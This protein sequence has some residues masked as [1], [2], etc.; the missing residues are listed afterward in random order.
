MNQ[1]FI[2]V[3]L[4]ILSLVVLAILIKIFLNRKNQNNFLYPSSLELKII[5]QKHISPKEKFIL[6]EFD[7]K[8][9]LLLLS[10]NGNILV[11]TIFAKQTQPKQQNN[12]KTKKQNED[13]DI[14]KFENILK[15]KGTNLEDYLKG[16]NVA[17]P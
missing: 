15:Q 16:K 5:Y 6:I 2:I 14:K 8:N 3:I 4:F 9:H 12:P 13:F 7:N 10:Q 11:D 17:T 1:K